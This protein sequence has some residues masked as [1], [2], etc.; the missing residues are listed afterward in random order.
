ME[1]LLF[2]V[3]PP[4]LE[5]S[6]VSD[7]RRSGPASRSLNSGAAVVRLS[8]E[9][10]PGRRASATVVKKRF[11]LAAHANAS[12]KSQRDEKAGPRKA[13]PAS[14]GRVDLRGGQRP[15]DGTTK[16]ILP[17]Q[18]FCGYAVVSKRSFVWPRLLCRSAVTSATA[19]ETQLPAFELNR[20]VRLDLSLAQIAEPGEVMGCACWRGCA[21]TIKRCK[22]GK[23]LRSSFRG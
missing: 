22:S 9:A 2:M 13:R 4:S 1:R 18:G 8:P 17:K 14:P 12:E 3:T 6:S 10:R 21:Q 16:I 11:K 20:F 19:Q 23:L 7:R 15:E 5:L